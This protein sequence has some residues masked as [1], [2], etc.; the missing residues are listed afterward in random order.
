[1]GNSDSKS[2]RDSWLNY[3]VGL[4]GIDVLDTYEDVFTEV[5]ETATGVERNFFATVDSGVDNVA[6]TANNLVNTVAN[7]FQVPMLIAV[8]IAMIIVY[9]LLQNPEPISRL[10]DVL[11]TLVERFLNIT[12]Q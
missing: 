12:E 1:M 3:W 7:T 5:S 11:L 6:Y 2:E 10:I 9:K 8:F 4:D